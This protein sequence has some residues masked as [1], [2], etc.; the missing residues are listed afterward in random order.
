MIFEFVSQ[1]IG[2]FFSIYINTSGII[3]IAENNKGA[4]IFPELVD[5]KI[6]QRCAVGGGEFSACDGVFHGGKRVRFFYASVKFFSSRIASRTEI[7]S[8]IL[9]Q[10]SQSAKSSQISIWRRSLSMMRM[11]DVVDMKER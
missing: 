2:G 6:K 11:S 8:S 1:K 7:S 5:F 9:S 4:R 10:P 3:S